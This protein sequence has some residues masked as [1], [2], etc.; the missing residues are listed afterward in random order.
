[1]VNGDKQRPWLRRGGNPLLRGDHL[2]SDQRQRRQCGTLQRLGVDGLAIDPRHRRHAD[3]IVQHR[4]AHAEMQGLA[5]RRV[6]A[7]VR[8]VAD[9]RDVIDIALLQP[10][11]QSSTG[12][13]ARQPLVDQQIAWPPVD[14]LAELKRRAVLLERP[15]PR[16]ADMPDNDDRH[17]CLRRTVHRLA[18]PFQALLAG[19]ELDGQPTGEVLLLDVDDDQRSCHGRHP[20]SCSRHIVGLGSSRS[21]YGYRLSK[22]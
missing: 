9:D 8:H 10:L 17:P 2:D 13:A 20:F 16:F 4:R 5:G 15:L 19:R 11:L 1:M 3:R 18:D 12:E 22:L 21:S 7:H 6:A 14:L